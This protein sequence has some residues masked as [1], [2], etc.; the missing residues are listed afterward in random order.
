MSHGQELGHEKAESGDLSPRWID[1]N[2]TKISVTMIFAFMG[3]IILCVALGWVGLFF[4]LI[5]VGF[6]VT[7]VMI[8]VWW[9]VGATED[10]RN[11]SH[12][13]GQNHRL[14]A[15]QAGMLIDDAA[16]ASGAVHWRELDD[17]QQA[18]AAEEAAKQKS[19]DEKAKK[20]RDEANGT[21]TDFRARRSKAKGL[22]PESNKIQKREAEEAK[23]KAAAAA[24]APP[25]T[26]SAS[27][28]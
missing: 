28:S 5:L 10:A 22:L 24:Q 23:R 18:N 9:L 15:Q 2:L 4:W 16:I 25:Q 17:Q 21:P 3:I 7:G 26:P 1:Q 6:L 11:A 12:T 13:A 19:M 27:P 20:E 14:R 8:F